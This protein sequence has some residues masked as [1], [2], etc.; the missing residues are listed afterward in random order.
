[1]SIIYTPFLKM[2]L[3]FF[4]LCNASLSSQNSYFQLLCSQIFA[5]VSHLPLFS[6]FV[7]YFFAHWSACAMEKVTME[8]QT[9][10]TLKERRKDLVASRP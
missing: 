1:M 5:Y 6:L 7:H 9:C 8:S 3:L 4:F 10:Y 2:L